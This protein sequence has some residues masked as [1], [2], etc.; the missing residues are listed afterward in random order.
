[1]RFKISRIFATVVAFCFAFNT[2]A[3]YKTDGNQQDLEIAK[4]EFSSPSVYTKDT[5]SLETNSFFSEIK[6]GIKKTCFTEGTLVLSQEICIPIE[7]ISIGDQ[8][9]SYN[10]TSTELRKSFVEDVMQFWTDVLIRIE[11]S[12]G[13]IVETTE[14]HP[15]YLEETK[16]WIQASLLELGD[17]V[18]GVDS[19]L[20]ITHMSRIHLSEPVRVFDISVNSTHNYFVLGYGS[21]TELESAVLVHNCNEVKE[22]SQ[23]VALGASEALPGAT[24][25]PASGSDAF[26]A[27]REAGQ[28]ASGAAQVVIGVA[29]VAAGETIA[30]LS[31]VE[32]A[33]AAAPVGAAVAGA[34]A[35]LVAH[36]ANVLGETI[37]K[38]QGE[39]T[40]QGKGNRFNE[41]QQ[42][43]VDMAKKDKRDGISSDDMQAYKDLNQELGDEGFLENQVRGPER[44]PNRPH[45]K[46]WHGHVG[47]VD[48]I[49]VNK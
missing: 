25:H 16:E 5:P 8:V 38:Q 15:F 11:F 31:C 23:G 27:G 37:F 43:L 26:E 1:M 33:C 21:C 3:I 48:H 40:A 17:V 41:E 35:G 46:E 2:F 13:R 36:G 14:N 24:Q 34:S 19:S 45:G 39:P 12:N 10:S 49:P 44:H 28:V 18:H 4:E 6:Q 42:S 32:A 47:P 22:F 29:G 7:Q 20:L 30:G 9:L